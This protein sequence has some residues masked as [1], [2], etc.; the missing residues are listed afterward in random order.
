MLSTQ[1][2][3]HQ[4]SSAQRFAFPDLSCN[5]NDTLLVLGRS[6]VGKTTLLHILAG[7]L[8]PSTGEVM[9]DGQSL[10][11]HNTGQLDNFRGKHIGLVF[12]KPH[13]VSALTAKENLQLA[14]KMAGNNIDNRRIDNLLFQLNID[15]RS[16]AKTHQMSQGEQQRL[17]I[18]RALVNEPKLILADEPTSALDDE[19]CT[20]VVSLLRRQAE[21]VG[22]ALVIVTHDGRLKELFD[23][24]VTLT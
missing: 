11:S 9:I 16:H 3:K 15:S 10:Y 20:E 6:G 17:S 2:L 18:A 4:Y 19:N 5:A 7:I 12:Q 1:E 22:A 24:Q 13:F 8:T 21:Q 14:Q 23:N